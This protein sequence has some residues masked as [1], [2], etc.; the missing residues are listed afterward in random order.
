MVD[1]NDVLNDLGSFDRWKYVLSMI[2]ASGEP[3][4]VD[5]IMAAVARWNPGAIAW[6]INET[7]SAGLARGQRNISDDNWLET[8]S[9]LR[10]AIGALLDGLGPLA[11]AFGPFRWA[12]VATLEHLSVIV[13]ARGSSVSTTWLISNQYPDHPLPPVVQP[14]VTREPVPRSIF[15]Q[16]AAIPLSR[17]W[18]WTTARNILRSD[19]SDNFTDLVLETASASD[20]IVRRELQD[21]RERVVM[22]PTDLDS[23]G[24]GL[25]GSLYPLPDVMPTPPAQWPG[26]SV[27]AITSRIYAVTRAAIECYIE[28]CNSVAPKFGDT[29]VHRG[30]MPFEYYG[31]LFYSGSSKPGMY[32]IG[33]STAGIQWL[34]RPIGVPL[35]NGERA[36]E[37]SVNLTVN[38]DARSQEIESNR[39]A[40]GDAYFLYVATTPGLEP[41]ADSFSVTSGQFDLVDKKPA[42]QMA[43]SWLWRDLMNLKWVHRFMPPDKTR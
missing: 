9:R 17:N 18:V 23:L 32:G 34:L 26:F 10:L 12:N 25:Y 27:E 4:R 1:I 24:R 15:M 19:L 2:L 7:E 16:Q 21:S 42:T 20:G 6:I 5:P 38:N 33:P 31:N 8:G 14:Q 11:G 36:G 13:E 22:D 37:N 3:S 29:L 30:M 40:F 41:F 43:L 35:P 28:L 39:D